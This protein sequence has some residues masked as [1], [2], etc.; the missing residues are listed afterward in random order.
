[1]I[2]AK[3]QQKLVFK[4]LWRAPDKIQLCENIQPLEIV[5]LSM[6]N[7]EMYFNSLIANC[8]NRIYDA[9]AITHN[10][11]QIARIFRLTSLN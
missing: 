10:W 1:M 4:F 3:E 5:G 8:L 9:D 2:L 7:V 6:I 11:A